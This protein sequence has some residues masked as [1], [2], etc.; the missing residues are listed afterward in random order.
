MRVSTR[1]RA[2]LVA[3]SLGALLLVAACGGSP[4]SGTTPTPSPKAKSVSVQTG[5]PSSP[6]TLNEDGSSLLLPYLQTLVSPLKQAY[7][8]ITLAPSAGG[9]GKGIADSIAGTVQMGGSDAYLSDA[10]AQQN[11]NLLNIPIAVSSQAVN[12]NLPGISSLNL[13]GNVLAQ[14]YE[15]KITKWNDPAIAKLNKGVNLPSQTIVP[16]RRVDSSGDT[17][18]FTSFL[19][20]TNSAWSN[21]PAFNTTVTWPAVQGELTASGN[22]GMVQTCE[23]TP[24]SIAYIGIS[25]EQTALSGKLG[26]AALQNQAGKFVKPTA[27]TAVAAV[28]AKATSIPDDLRASLIYASG[29]QSYPIVNYEYLMI[30]SQQKDA[31]TAL[32][33]RTFLTWAIDPARGAT[34]ANLGTVGFNPLPA[35]VV[36]KVHTAINKIQSS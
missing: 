22:P 29:A 6:V 9:S 7:P 13:S 10:Q 5:N 15:G 19:S 23:Q 28:A 31:N 16:I 35:T 2:S 24:G 30:S 25:V 4:S 26:Q 3:A 8:N 17:F 21:G 18:I 1:L 20:A 27:A 36:P 32:A 33:L 12:F 34:T 14:I 11:P